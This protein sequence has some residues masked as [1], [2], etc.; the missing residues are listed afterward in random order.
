[1][2]HSQKRSG[3]L[4]NLGVV[5]NYNGFIKWQIPVAPERFWFVSLRVFTWKHLSG[6]INP[7]AVRII[8]HRN[9][10]MYYEGPM[11]LFCF[12][13]LSKVL[14]LYQGCREVGRRERDSWKE[15]ERQNEWGGRGSKSKRGSKSE[16]GSSEQGEKYQIAQMCSR[17]N[18]EVDRSQGQGRRLLTL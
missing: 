1:M 12:S 18:L 8:F 15:K 7:W 4:S 10:L 16:I 3:A 5:S 17:G 13:V 6:Q 11:S 14:S 2:I 9:I